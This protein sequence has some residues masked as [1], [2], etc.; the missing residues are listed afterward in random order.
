MKFAVIKTGGKQYLVS[1]GDVLDVEKLD[2]KEKDK[3]EFDEVL[4]VAD[5]KDVTMGTPFISGKKVKAEVL[6]E[7]KDKKV[8]GVKHKAKKRYTKKF[9]HRQQYTQIK[10]TEL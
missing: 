6:K 2:K 4:M 3:I 10:I 8:V 7:Y 5:D 9:G 1:K